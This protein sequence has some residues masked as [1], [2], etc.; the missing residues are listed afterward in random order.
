VTLPPDTFFVLYPM[1]GHSSPRVTPYSARRITQTLEQVGGDA[2]G[3]EIRQDVNGNA[4]DLT[5]PQFEK[6]L[7]TVTCRDMNAPSLDRAW[8]GVRAQMAC[9]LELNYLT[10]GGT[11]ARP[12]VSGSSRVGHGPIEGLYTFYRP[13]LTVIV[14]QV[15][16]GF[17]ERNHDYNWMIRAR[18]L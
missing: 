14:T 6:W 2:L 7:T 13:L 12:E 1:S 8:K 10:A 17:D 5:Q 16:Q 18:E 15:T 3:R 9:A 4:V 11:P